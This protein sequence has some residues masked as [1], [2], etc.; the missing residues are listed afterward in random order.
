MGGGFGQGQSDQEVAWYVI[1][2]LLSLEK[3][4]DS[5]RVSSSGILTSLY[6]DNYVSRG[7]SRLDDV[8]IAFIPRN[9]D[10]DYKTIEDPSLRQLEDIYGDI[11]TPFSQIVSFTS[12]SCPDAL[13]LFPSCLCMEENDA[14]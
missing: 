10:R 5:R 11:N 6:V 14:P 4:R 1:N 13:F 9:I 8:P 2:R 12:L 3:A 7:E